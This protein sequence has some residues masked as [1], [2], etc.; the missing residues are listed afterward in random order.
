[1]RSIYHHITEEKSVGKKGFAVLVDPDKVDAD[2][3]NEICGSLQKLVSTTP[4]WRKPGR[5]QPPG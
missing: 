4:R 2:K 1:M 5:D 3:I